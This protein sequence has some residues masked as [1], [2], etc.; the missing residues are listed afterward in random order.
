LVFI[1]YFYKHRDTDR[2]CTLVALCS[3]RFIL[4]TR[5]GWMDRGSEEEETGSVCVC[6]TSREGALVISGF[7]NE[8]REKKENEKERKRRIIYSSRPS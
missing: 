3:F 1:I 4:L 2:P 5:G 8:R 6:V 7:R